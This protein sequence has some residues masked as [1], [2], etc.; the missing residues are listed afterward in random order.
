MNFLNF[1]LSTSIFSN[2]YANCWLWLS[3]ET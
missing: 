1:T 3:I 2:C